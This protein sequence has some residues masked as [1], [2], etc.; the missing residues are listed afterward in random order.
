MQI[1]DKEKNILAVENGTT[2]QTY[3]YNISLTLWIARF[4][5]IKRQLLCGIYTLKH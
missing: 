3:T 1:Y 5:T 4:E 2:P